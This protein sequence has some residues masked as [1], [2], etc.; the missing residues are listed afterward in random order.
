MSRKN[1]IECEE[2]GYS[3]QITHTGKQAINF[4]PFCGEEVSVEHVDRPLLNN[5]DDLD[6]YDDYDED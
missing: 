4:C 2:C 6:E 1:N 3:C 5:F